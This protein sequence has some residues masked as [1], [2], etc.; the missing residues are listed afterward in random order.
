MILLGVLFFGWTLV[1]F[2]AWYNMREHVQRLDTGDTE[3]LVRLILFFLVIGPFGWL[4]MTVA[5]FIGMISSI[6]KVK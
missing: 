5:A 2:L 4:L 6:L 3:G 1:G